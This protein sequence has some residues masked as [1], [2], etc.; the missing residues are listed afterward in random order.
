VNEPTACRRAGA[1]RDSANMPMTVAPRPKRLGRG[2]ARA[3]P[4]GKVVGRAG[5]IC[6]EVHLAPPFAFSTATIGISEES[7]PQTW[8]RLRRQGRRPPRR[9]LMTGLEPTRRCTIRTAALSRPPRYVS[10]SLQAKGQCRRDLRHVAICAQPIYSCHMHRSRPETVDLPMPF[11]VV[12]GR[13]G[14]PGR[15]SRSE[16]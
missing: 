16:D 6:L 11:H 13:R 14:R 4:S 8:P 3:P 1:C 2:L 5:S 12:T 15:A 7:A 10:S 9:R